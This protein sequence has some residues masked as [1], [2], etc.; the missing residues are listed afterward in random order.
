MKPAQKEGDSTEMTSFCNC[1]N[2]KR[3]CFLLQSGKLLDF[4][5]H[6]QMT[7]LKLWIF[8]WPKSR[9]HFFRRDDAQIQIFGQTMKKTLEC[10]KYVRQWQIDNFEKNVLEW[11]SHFFCGRCHNVVALPRR[12]EEIIVILKMKIRKPRQQNLLVRNSIS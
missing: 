9:S 2:K 11:R 4:F 3:K 5:L 8:F 12:R 1:C 6:W 10:T 7:L